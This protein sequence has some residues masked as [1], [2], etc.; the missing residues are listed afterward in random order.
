[1]ATIHSNTRKLVSE[2][3]VA[4]MNHSPPPPAITLLSKSVME[5]VTFSLFQLLVNC[6]ASVMEFSST[7][8]RKDSNMS[9]LTGS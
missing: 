4:Q 6:I 8:N 3:T 2:R 9:F 7:A 5:F 1:V